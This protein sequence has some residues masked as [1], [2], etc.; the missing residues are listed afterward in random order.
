MVYSTETYNPKKSY[1]LMEV[2]FFQNDIFIVQKFDFKVKSIV[3]QLK[4]GTIIYNPP[5]K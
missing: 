1:Y 4:N 3:A 5:E 2:T